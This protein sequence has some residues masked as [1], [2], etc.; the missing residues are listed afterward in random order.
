MPSATWLSARPGEGDALLEVAL[1]LPVVAPPD[2][3]DRQVAG[4]VA[5]PSEVATRHRGAQRLV[6]PGARLVEVAQRGR[7]QPALVQGVCDASRIAHLPERACASS[8]AAL[9]GA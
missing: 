9:A 5:R 1:R 7:D 8:R 6:E 4:H 2:R 3:Q